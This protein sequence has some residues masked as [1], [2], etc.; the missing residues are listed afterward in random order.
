MAKSNMFTFTSVYT[1]LDG[2]VAA[3]PSRSAPDS[4]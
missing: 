2:G 4:R 3:V 1:A